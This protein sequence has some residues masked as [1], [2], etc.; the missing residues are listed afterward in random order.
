MRMMGITP[1][2]HSL[3]WCQENSAFVMAGTDTSYDGIFVS[4]LAR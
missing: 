3:R 2:F 1:K 4:I